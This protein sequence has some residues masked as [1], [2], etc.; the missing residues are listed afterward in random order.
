MKIIQNTNW[1]YASQS[2]FPIEDLVETL[3]NVVAP[4][5]LNYHKNF[6]HVAGV[7]SK[8]AISS[9][10]MT[11]YKVKQVHK[12]AAHS[13]RATYAKR[14]KNIGCFWSRFPTTR[15]GVFKKGAHQSNEGISLDELFKAMDIYAETIFNYVGEPKTHS[16]LIK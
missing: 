8:E 7:C 14:C 13:R 16:V 9:N 15:R 1:I 12:L 4:Y 2:S 6:D 3:K 10:V 5:G 11:I